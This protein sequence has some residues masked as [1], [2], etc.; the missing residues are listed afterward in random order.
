MANASIISSVLGAA[1]GLVV[2]A[3]TSV[4]ET[5]AAPPNSLGYTQWL[6]QGTMVTG[7][8]QRN[9]RRWIGLPGVVPGDSRK[10]LED[11]GYDNA[12]VQTPAAGLP[13]PPGVPVLNPIQR[14]TQYKPVATSAGKQV[15][16]SQGGE[17]LLNW[18]LLD[19]ARSGTLT[20]ANTPLGVFA[21]AGGITINNTD[22]VWF[23]LVAATAGAAAAGILTPVVA[24]IQPS[25]GFTLTGAAPIPAGETWRYLVVAGPPV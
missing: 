19:P 21:P 15:G 11:F 18:G 6:E 7:A 4:S 3:V 2:P 8:G 14:Y 23:F 20:S 25:V 12:V 1:P 10:T 5:V 13:I 17:V 16:A 9:F 22:Q 24:S